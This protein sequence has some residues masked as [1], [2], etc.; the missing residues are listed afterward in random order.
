MHFNPTRKLAKLRFLPPDFASI[1]TDLNVSSLIDLAWFQDRPLG[2]GLGAGR[3][4]LLN[5]VVWPRYSE[6]AHSRLRQKALVCS[7]G[8]LRANKGFSKQTK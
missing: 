6:E 5:V 8:C 7:K 1:N 2:W 4:V 3:L